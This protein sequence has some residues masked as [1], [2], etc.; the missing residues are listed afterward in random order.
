MRIKEIVLCGFKSYGKRTVLRDF[1]QNLN[2]ITGLN[3]SGKSNVMDGVCFVLGLQAFSMARVDKM[4]GLIYKSGQSGI[5]EASVTLKFDQL[6]SKL[7]HYRW[8]CGGELV[9]TRTI[10]RDKSFYSMNGKK[11]TLTSMKNLFKSVGLNMDNPSSF[12][13]RQGTITH[14][15]GFKGKFLLEMVE[16]CAGVNYYNGI[17]RQFD[18]IVQKH[19]FKMEDVEKVYEED[20]N[21]ELQKLSDEV[22][23]LAR[24]RQV[25]VELQLVERYRKNLQNVIS[26][27]E[28]KMMK[29]QLRQWNHDRLDAGKK[30]RIL[31]EEMGSFESEL[32][33]VNREISAERGDELN[34][35]KL[36]GLEKGYE[37]GMLAVNIIKTRTM[38]STKKKISKKETEAAD[39]EAK[40]TGGNQ[41]LKFLKGEVNGVDEERMRA[42]D[43]LNALKNRASTNAGGG[44][45]LKVQKVQLEKDVSRILNEIIERKSHLGRVKQRVVNLAGEQEELAGILTERQSALLGLEKQEQELDLEKRKVETEL[46]TLESSSD[47]RQKKEEQLNWQ[48]KMR[49]FPSNMKQKLDIVYNPNKVQYNNRYGEIF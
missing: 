16:E 8:F 31:K 32:A 11:V 17:R 3:G 19:N 12:F 39:L 1:D 13:V 36:E 28:M 20:L 23:N 25:C 22:S 14:I 4:Q 35:R 21:P 34:R 38:V 40:I 42:R 9:V 30:V 15:S 26:E 2:C 24:F 6:D 18:R 44:G 41:R 29:M 5:T 43:M 48:R 10:R 37:K 47:F 27:N 33:K 46:I 7:R 45:I 49:G